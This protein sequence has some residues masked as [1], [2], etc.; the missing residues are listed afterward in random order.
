MQSCKGYKRP[1]ICF[2]NTEYSFIILLVLDSQFSQI[3]IRASTGTEKK[4]AAAFE[5][6]AKQ[7]RVRERDGERQ[8]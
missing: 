3:D 8:Q 1:D 4:K 5:K 7:R 2:I 6:F